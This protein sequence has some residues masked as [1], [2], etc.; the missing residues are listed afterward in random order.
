MVSPPSYKRLR[1]LTTTTINTGYCCLLLVV[2]QFLVHSRTTIQESQTMTTLEQRCIV[3]FLIL[4]CTEYS[5]ECGSQ[6]SFQILH[7]RHRQVLEHQQ[8]RHDHQQSVVETSTIPSSVSTSETT[9]TTTVTT[10]TTTIVTT[11]TLSSTT[12]KVKIPN[13]E[14]PKS[15]QTTKKKL[16]T[17]TFSNNLIPSKILSTNIGRFEGCQLFKYL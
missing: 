8:Q 2:L 5:I 14:Y 13:T 15:F 9:T 3:A 1:L 6:F 12:S 17:K 7:P 16:S 4:L 11:T 10:T